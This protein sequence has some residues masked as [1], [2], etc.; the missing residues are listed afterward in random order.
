MLNNQWSVYGFVLQRQFSRAVI[1]LT[2]RMNALGIAL[3]G[4]NYKEVTVTTLHDSS[5]EKGLAD[6]SVQ[7]W[8]AAIAYIRPPYQPTDTEFS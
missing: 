5:R 1:T 8:A 6:S 3:L 7:G 4:S 2:D